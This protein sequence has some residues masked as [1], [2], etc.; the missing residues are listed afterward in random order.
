MNVLISS[1]QVNLE[2]RQ[3]GATPPVLFAIYVDD[4]LVK[5]K[6]NS[7]RLGCTV[8]GLTVNSECIWD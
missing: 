7:S 3:S 8:K 1:F 4:V 2:V 5:L 6:L